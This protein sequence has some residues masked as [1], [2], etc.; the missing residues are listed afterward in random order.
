MKTFSERAINFFWLWGEPGKRPKIVS[1]M[2]PDDDT[3][4]SKAFVLFS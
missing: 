2:N 4:E 3:V 1:V